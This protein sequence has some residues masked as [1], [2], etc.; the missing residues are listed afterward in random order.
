MKV[1][2]NLMSNV[3]IFDNYKLETECNDMK[4]TFSLDKFAFIKIPS[5]C[6]IKNKNFEV[7][8]KH[9]NEFNQD[10]INGFMY[11]PDLNFKV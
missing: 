10:D 11:Y 8:M 5:N 6:E 7:T 3:S 2:A 1:R 9:K 4:Q